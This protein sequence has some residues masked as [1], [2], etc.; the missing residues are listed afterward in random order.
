MNPAQAAALIRASGTWKPG[1]PITVH[2]CEVAKGGN[3]FI[4]GL[5]NN[6]NVPVT[7]P[8]SLLLARLEMLYSEV[9]TQ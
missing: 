8:N 7:G 5:A 6:L 2:A 3:N 4:Q 9:C 1:M